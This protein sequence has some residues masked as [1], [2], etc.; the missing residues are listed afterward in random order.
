MKLWSVFGATLIALLLATAP[1][2]AAL[3][4]QAALAKGNQL[5]AAGDLE[6]AVAAYLEGCTVQR[7]HPTLAYNLAT[8]LHQLERLPEAVLWYRRA[9]QVEDPWLEENLWLARR[10][11]GSQQLNVVDF[12]SQ[13]NARAELLLVL[14]LALSWLAAGAWLGRRKLTRG[15]ALF[16][17]AA[18]LVVLILLWLAP[19]LAA[20]PAVLLS[21]C[22][23]P[24]GDLPAGTE[25]MVK[26]E[27]ASWRILGVKGTLCPKSSAELVEN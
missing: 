25:V 26:N 24:A 27:G 15:P 14:A 1:L 9:A 18:A 10:S 20:R 16:T 19:S 12:W 6:G 11:L 2:E 23:G 22:S 3:D 8:T 17:L 4:P 7:P 13:L 5:S 21:P